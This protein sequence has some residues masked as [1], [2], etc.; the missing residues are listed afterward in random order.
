MFRGHKGC[1]LLIM[2][3]NGHDHSKKVVVSVKRLRAQP[4]KENNN[5]GHKHN[6]QPQNQKFTS[7]VSIPWLQVFFAADHDH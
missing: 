3:I 5:N 4:H 2:T 1:L 6:N 7:T